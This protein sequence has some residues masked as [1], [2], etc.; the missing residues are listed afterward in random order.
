MELTG[1][2]SG[3]SALEFGGV[4]I[5][6]GVFAVIEAAKYDDIGANDLQSDLFTP[7]TVGVGGMDEEGNVTSREFYLADVSSITGP[8]IVVPDIGGRKN[9]YFQVKSRRN[10]AKEFVHWLKTAH[11][12]MIMSDEEDDLVAEHHNKRAKKV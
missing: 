3:R 10:W 2:P 8:C 7:I 6:N 4:R 9:A 12:D 5:E 11:D 1:L